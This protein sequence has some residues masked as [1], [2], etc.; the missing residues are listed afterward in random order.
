M[1][2][3]FYADKN[4]PDSSFLCMSILVNRCQ[5]QTSLSED[6]TKYYIVALNYLSNLY[7]IVYTD[8]Y[9]AHTY[10]L[11]AKELA[12]EN[13]TD[14]LPYIYLTMGNLYLV[15]SGMSLDKPNYDKVL[16]AYKH[17]FKA[18]LASEQH[19]CISDL[20]VNIVQVALGEDMLPSIRQEIKQYAQFDIPQED[21]IWTYA[22]NLCRGIQLW[23]GG[24]HDKALQEFYDLPA[25]G[26]LQPDDLLTLVSYDITYHALIQIGR[27]E[28]ALHMLD[29]MIVWAKKYDQPECLTDAYRYCYEYYK[30]KNDHAQTDK[31]ELLWRQQRDSTIN[32]THM[33]SFQ[34][35]SFLFD[36]AKKNDQMSKMAH[37]KQMQLR[38]LIIITV[39]SVFAIAIIVVLLINRRRIQQNYRQLYQK[40]DQLAVNEQ[41]Q[42]GVDIDIATD[43]KSIPAQKYSHNQID[44]E[45][46]AE[47]LRQVMHIME[48]SEEIYDETFSIERL[49]EM[50]STKKIYIS[51]AINVGTGQPFSTLLNGF[52]IK[53]ACRRMSDLGNYGH[54][55]VEGI[56]QSVGYSSRSHFS[57]LFKNFTGLTPSAYQKMA[58]EGR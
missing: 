16:D 43:R 6:E 12:E 39:F 22:K 4:M 49:A 35:A 36:M 10:I 56:A 41:R 58:K 13:Y 21:G 55:S 34:K 5:A 48:T 42:S 9:K 51:Q 7:K 47:I 29:T 26:Q 19:K 52:R 8:Y 17:G 38:I 15:E 54:Y 2:N 37:K 30:G 28:E 31:Y 46:S 32:R 44:D 18:S 40:L 20:F 33:S 3:S 14:Y 24:N 25:T 27:E 57:K 23:Q 50:M 1:G 11:K 53:E 45:V